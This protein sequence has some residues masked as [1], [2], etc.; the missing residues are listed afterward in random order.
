MLNSFFTFSRGINQKAS[1]SIGKFRECSWNY[2]KFLRFFSD[3]NYVGTS[4]KLSN[5]TKINKNTVGVSEKQ[6]IEKSNFSKSRNF[7]S[8]QLQVSTTLNVHIRFV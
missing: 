1:C 6:L 3:S 7:E 5:A 8:V 2:R 4:T